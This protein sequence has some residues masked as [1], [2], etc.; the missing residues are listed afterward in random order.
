MSLHRVSSLESWD[1][2]INNERRNSPQKITFNPV[3]GLISPPK[4]EL[5]SLTP[6]EVSKGRRIGKST[7]VNSGTILIGP[8]HKL[9]SPA[10]TVSSLRESFLDMPPLNKYW[11][12]KACIEDSVL[13]QINP[14]IVRH[15]MNR[16]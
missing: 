14:P 16:S 11:S 10:Y 15:A 6:K 7:Q 9:S 1:N 3:A 12:Q 4:I 13:L 5:W 2:P 8:K